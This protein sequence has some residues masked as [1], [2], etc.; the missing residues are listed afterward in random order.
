MRRSLKRKMLVLLLVLLGGF[1]SV[2]LLFLLEMEEISKHNV[3]NQE[4]IVALNEI[5]KLT[6]Q[7][8]IS[9]AKQQIEE[10][11]QQLGTWNGKL[12]QLFL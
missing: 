5:E 3:K 1:S 11:R 2:V 9:P 7:E 4:Q 6:E 8:G 10:F 12:A